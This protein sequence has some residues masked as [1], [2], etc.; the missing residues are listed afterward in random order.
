M[1]A[2]TPYAVL[3]RQ[4]GPR[5]NSANSFKI[6][7]GV[8][9]TRLWVKKIIDYETD[10]ISAISGVDGGDRDE[11]VFCAFERDNAG[12]VHLF[13]QRLHRRPSMVYDVHGPQVME[14][15]KFP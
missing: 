7:P 12:T 1:A 8:A 3:I 4:A 14:R 9:M 6:S 13:F 10:E 5:G 15:T 2:P 11:S